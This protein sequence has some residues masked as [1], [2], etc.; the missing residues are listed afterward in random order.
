MYGQQVSHVMIDKINILI[1]LLSIFKIENLIIFGM[2]AIVMG[3][4]WK[5]TIG[6]D[7][8]TKW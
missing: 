7:K 6:I 1:H 8:F 5:D 2:L 4:V 3:P